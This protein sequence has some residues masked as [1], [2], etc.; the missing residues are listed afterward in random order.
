MKDKLLR[1]TLHQDKA[2]YRKE[3]SY[4]NK[5]TYPLP[6]YSTVIGAIHK[7]CGYTEYKPMDIS[8]SGNYQSLQ[9]EVYR[10]QGFL[11]SVMDD[12]GI[13]VKLQNP[14]LFNDGYYIVAKAKKPQ[15]NSFRNRVSIDVIDEEE[16]QNFIRLSE[17]RGYYQEKGNEIKEQAQ[18]ITKNINA[19]RAKQKNIDKQS[20]E[21]A[22]ITTD[23]EQL[24]SKKDSLL[25]D[26]KLEQEREYSTPYSYYASLTT[27][28][29]YYEV[30]YNVDLVIHV[31]ST[32]NVLEDIYKNIHNLTAIGRSED[33]VSNVQVEYVDCYDE[34]SDESSAIEQIFTC[35][36][37][38]SEA[39]QSKAIFYPKNAASVS[40]VPTQG[41]KYYLNKN[42]TIEKGKRIFAKIAANY[43]SNYKIKLKKLK[44][45]NDNHLT[46]LYLDK[47]GYIV[48]LA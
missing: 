44:D 11:N 45:Y 31:R 24:K 32:A 10:D 46:K 43:L 25:N 9:K 38:M 40:E 5:M 21:Y 35:G 48:C 36:Y 27:S 33:F 8:I 37:V 23:L 42:Y 3:E 14:D 17:L 7:A 39:L 12:R 47:D 16:L 15:G 28:I 34:E 19:L 2:H 6:P 13:L 1:I 29:K 26:F 18:E 20:D 22:S 4:T 30:L 41:T